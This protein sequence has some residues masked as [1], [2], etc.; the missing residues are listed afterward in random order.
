MKNRNYIV[1]TLIVCFLFHSILVNSACY[2]PL[3]S[4]SIN[5]DFINSYTIAYW[6]FNENTGNTLYDQSSNLNDGIISGAI[7][8]EGSNYSA[9]EFNGDDY[10]MFPY[11]S[12]LQYISSLWTIEA[13]MKLSSTGTQNGCA[14]FMMSAVTPTGG[15]AENNFAIYATNKANTNM[16]SITIKD[17]YGGS[18]SQVFDYIPPLDKWILIDVVSSADWFYLF[19]NGTLIDQFMYPGIVVDHSSK[20]HVYIG[21]DEDSDGSLSDFFYGIIDEFVIY[22]TS[23]NS[24]T[25]ANHYNYYENID[26]FPPTILSSG[27]LSYEIGTLN[28]FINWTL[29]DKNP[30]YYEIYRDDLL[31]FNDTWNNNKQIVWNVDSLTSG[32]YNYTIIAYD[33]KGQFSTNS[34]LVEV[35]ELT[36]TQTE[37]SVTLF[38]FTILALIVIPIVSMKKKRRK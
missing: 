30:S 9:L 12:S 31:I 23:L 8:V 1:T 11:S 15:G 18:Y 29:S 16:V 6:N 25:I 22:D 32:T 24:G 26:L 21:T 34:V 2:K 3:I 33:L 20:G 38:E 13:F 4:D 27:N 10:V 14:L 35:Y 5:N 7:W 17:Q 37:E 19:I 28:N 36:E